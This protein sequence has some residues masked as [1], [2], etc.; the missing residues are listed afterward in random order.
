MAKGISIQK[1]AVNIKPVFVLLKY[2]VV[3]LVYSPSWLL[4]AALC[5]AFCIAKSCLGFQKL[6]VIRVIEVTT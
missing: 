1:T 6:A 2:E 3:L 4:L 5:E